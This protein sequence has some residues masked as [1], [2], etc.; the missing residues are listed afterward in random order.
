M[1]RCLACT[2]AFAVLQGQHSDD[3]GSPVNACDLIWRAPLAPGPGPKAGGRG[4]G[5]VS[6]L[7]V[8][9]VRGAA[10]PDGDD[11]FHSLFQ[12]FLEAQAGR[13]ADGPHAPQAEG[14][15]KDE[16]K[17]DAVCVS[18]TAAPR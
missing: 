7:N 8:E 12:R 3:L 4:Q 14:R 16:R 5:R 6:V 1:S 17:S 11:G 2:A 15:I 18:A 13:V 10:A 9:A